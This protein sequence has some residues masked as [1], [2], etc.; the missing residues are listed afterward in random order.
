VVSLPRC[1]H[2]VEAPAIAA[3]TSDPTRRRVMYVEDN[4]D[5][6]IVLADALESTG[7]EVQAMADATLALDA[8]AH[9]TPDVVILDL[10][11]PGIDGFELATRLRARLGAAVGLIALSGYGQPDDR[12]RSKAAGIDVHL[13]K[14]VQLVELLAHL[15]RF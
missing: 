4:E 2:V 9:F 10:G 12:E 7:H 15:Q 1:H 5:A 11:L 14:P 6:R 3:P 8:L 13:T